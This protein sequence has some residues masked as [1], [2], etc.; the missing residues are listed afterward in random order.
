MTFVKEMCV[1]NLC[2]KLRVFDTAGDGMQV[3][4][5]YSVILDGEE[6]A[7]GGADF[8]YVVTKHF[9]GDCPTLCTGNTPD[10]VDGGGY[11]CGSYEETDLPGCP[12]WRRISS[13]RWVNCQ[14]CL[15]WRYGKCK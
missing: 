15:D 13:C 10:W 1:P 5:G 14:P 3:P 12:V 6:V 11:G 7:C 2:I 4:G 8:S 9:T